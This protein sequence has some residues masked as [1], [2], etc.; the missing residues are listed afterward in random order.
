MSKTLAFA[1]LFVAAVAAVAAAAEIKTAE[2]QFKNIQVLKGMPAS[3][4]NATMDVMSGA[5]G[6]ECNHCHVMGGPGQ[7]PAMEKDDK[8]AKRT[9]RKMVTMMQKINKDFFGGELAVTCATC[10]N[11]RAE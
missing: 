3:Q 7:A 5:L 4:L 6:V 8:G 9:A 10:H 1:W 2:Q 11:G